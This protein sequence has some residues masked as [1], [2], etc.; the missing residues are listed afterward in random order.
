MKILLVKDLM[1]LL[2]ASRPSVYRWLAERR[3]G[4][5]NFPLPISQAGR[6]LR[7]NSDDIE[8]YCQSRAAPQ[9]PVNVVS[10]AKQQVKAQR[11]QQEATLQALA[12]HKIYPNSKTG[13]N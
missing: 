7:W 5:G 4:F 12:R 11:E 1:R 6:Q 13:D 3:A 2:R 9:S 10:T 8:A